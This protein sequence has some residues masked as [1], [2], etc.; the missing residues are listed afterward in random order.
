MAGHS[1]EFR[2]AE[3]AWADRNAPQNEAGAI[4]PPPRYCFTPAIAFSA[5]SMTC[6]GVA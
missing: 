2:F 3:E 6:F 4:A 1:V 5:L